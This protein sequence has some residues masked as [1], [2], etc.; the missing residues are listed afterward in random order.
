[1]RRT[2][3]TSTNSYRS[4]KRNTILWL[5]AANGVEANPRGATPPSPVNQTIQP[6]QQPVIPRSQSVG[7]VAKLDTPFI[8]VPSPRMTSELNLLITTNATNL[9]IRYSLTPA[10]IPPVIHL[11][12][13]VHQPRM[14]TTSG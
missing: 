13:G 7:I 11:L 3:C 10:R 1:M 8:N 6:T 9:Q 2:S 4:L 12:N 14:R 5:V